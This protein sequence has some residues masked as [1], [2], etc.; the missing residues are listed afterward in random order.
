MTE[1]GGRLGWLQPLICGGLLRARP[2]TDLAVIVIV[3]I[4]LIIVVTL[5]SSVVVRV[6]FGLPFLLFFPGYTLVAALFPK[7]T[8]LRGIERIAL[9]FGLSI[10]VVPLIGLILNYTPWGIALY[11]ILAALTI[12]VLIASGLAWYRRSRLPDEERFSVQCSI[13]LPSW[14]GMGQWDKVLSVVLAAS[15]LGAIGTIAYVVASPRAGEQFTEFYVLG[16]DGMAEG[17][18]SELEVGEEARVILGI[19]NH[20]LEEESYL[21]EIRIDGEPVRTVGPVVVQDEGKWEEETAF[22]PVRAG[23]EQKVEFLLF[24]DIDQQPYRSLYLWIDVVG[25]A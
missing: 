7:R 3:S 17:Y 1:A 14:A 9:G 15:I 18:P 11:P 4:L 2:G 5:S 25:P 22:A 16:L 6:I 10:A 24:R 13:T 19:A 20:E 21:V 23:T 12:F 8:D